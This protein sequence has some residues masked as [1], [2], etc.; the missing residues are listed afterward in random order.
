MGVMGREKFIQKEWQEQKFRDKN[1][2]KVWAVVAHR[3]RKVGWARLGG[4]KY[5]YIYI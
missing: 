5:I 2:W 4:K 3:A 1:A